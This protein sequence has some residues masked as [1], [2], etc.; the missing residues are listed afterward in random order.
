MCTSST[1]VQ[2]EHRLTL[3]S[4]GQRLGRRDLEE[5]LFICEACIPESI[6]EEITSATALFRELEH[7]VLIGP[8]NYEFLRTVFTNIGR[9]DLA[10]KLTQFKAKP[11]PIAVP[12]SSKKTAATSKRSVLQ[13]VADSLR[14]KDLQKLSFLCYSK[15]SDGLSLIKDLEE[16]R[17]ICQDDYGYLE[18]KLGVIGRHDLRK[19]LSSG[20]ETAD[21]KKVR[22]EETLVS[23]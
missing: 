23:W 13:V 22:G 20:Q 19:L 4:I 21:G 17:L 7:R 15:Y 1:I 8:G 12:V 5:M 18:Q 2:F 11:K 10:N 3:S 6:A 14:K 9:I 16:K